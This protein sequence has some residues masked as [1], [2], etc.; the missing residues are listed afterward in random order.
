MVLVAFFS[1]ISR[2][3]HRNAEN[4]SLKRRVSCRLCLVVVEDEGREGIFRCP[5]CFADNER[6]RNRSLG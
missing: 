1:W 5:H 6:G 4:R 2:W 3:S